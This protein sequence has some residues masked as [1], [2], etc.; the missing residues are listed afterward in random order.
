MH[1]RDES[2][3]Q[4]FSHMMGQAMAT[5][6]QQPATNSDARFLFTLFAP[7]R[8]LRLKK[9]LA[10]QFEGPAVTIQ[11][12]EGGQGATLI[13]ERNKR[14]LTVL[15]RQLESGGKRIAIFYGAGHVPDLSDRLI[16][17]FGLRPAST[18]WITAWDLR[19]KPQQLD[20][21][22]LTSFLYSLYRMFHTGFGSPYVMRCDLHRSAK[23][24][25]SQTI[26]TS[27]RSDVAGRS[28][29]ESRH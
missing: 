7:G 6:F 9:L 24:R 25:Y 10:K 8:E 12:L 20:L 3:L 16:K 27:Y 26:G 14:C 28:D 18:K 11:A 23:R 19:S 29:V 2:F 1:T 5:Q 17:D 15:R 22:A 4:M 21:L 13:G